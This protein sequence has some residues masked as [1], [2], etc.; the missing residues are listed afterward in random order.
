MRLRRAAVIATLILLAWAATA[1]AECAWVSWQW[2]V[3]MKEDYGHDTPKDRVAAYP[4]QAAC[5][6]DVHARA[7][8]IPMAKEKGSKVYDHSSGSA[9]QRANGTTT[10]FECWPDTVDPRGPKGK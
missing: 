5:M 9:V 4:T 6:A 1:G 8:S 10:S 3:G 7:W 2:M